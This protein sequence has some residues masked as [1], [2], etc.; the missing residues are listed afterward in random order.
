MDNRY[1][2]R[3][4]PSN[5]PTDDQGNSFQRRTLPSGTGCEVLKNFLSLEVLKSTQE[6]YAPN[7]T[8]H[9][10]D[11]HWAATCST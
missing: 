8:L 3:K 1:V 7:V 5:R 10:W 2:E 11:Y 6:S 4:Q 9:F